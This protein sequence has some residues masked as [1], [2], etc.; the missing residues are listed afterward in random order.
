VTAPA[1]TTIAGVSVL[2]RDRRH[3][4]A[5]DLGL[6]H[7]GIE[8]RRPGRDPRRVAWNR[9]SE[10]EIEER[11]GDVVLTLRTVGAATRLVITGWSVAELEAVLRSVTAPSDASA[12]RDAVDEGP[13]AVEDEL[14]TGGGG[15]AAVTPIDAAA[16]V[17]DP[18]VTTEPAQPES[19]QPR[20][21]RRRG[22]RAKRV[23]T[24]V[25]LVVLA[26]AVTLVLLQSAGIIDWGF[27]GPTA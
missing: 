14:E 5:F 16:Q 8:F 3:G 21:Q 18:P 19:T 15:Q 22:V 4:E 9:V 17:A 11:S 2:T 1:S 25:L 26:A 23:L 27:L 20:G 10:W 12:E 6:S 7:A 24:V 13:V